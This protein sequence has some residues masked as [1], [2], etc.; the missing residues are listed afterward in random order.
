[1]RP[2]LEFRNK[3]YQS[4]QPENS[5]EY[6]NYKRR[7]GRVAYNSGDINDDSVTEVRHVPGPYWLKVRRDFLRELLQIEKSIRSSGQDIEL[8]TRPELHQIRQEWLKDPN[9]PDWEDSL[10][11]I[12]REVYGNELDW[13]ENDA[14]AF[15]KVD[16]SILEE[17]SAKYRIPSSMVRKLLEAEL[18]VAGLGKR[19]GILQKIESILRQDWEE[20]D[21]VNERNQGLRK[22]GKSHVD[23]V[24]KEFAE[25]LQ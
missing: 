16:S 2:L 7:T 11:A 20:L 19:R 6:R 3:L 15:T 5:K 1:M 14:G 18:Q 17:L 12:Y 21:E 13:V 4:R 9:E 8:I 10:P 22:L 24:R 25:F 23:E